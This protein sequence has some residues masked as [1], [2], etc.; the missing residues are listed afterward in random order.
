VTG[1][2]LAGIFAA[3]QST[4]SSSINSAA[5][6]ILCDL[7]KRYVRPGAGERESLHV[8]RAATLLAGLAGTGA[9]LALLRI[10]SALDAWWQLA[11]ILSG[12][13]L[14][15]FL[16]G[17]LSRAGSRAAFAAVVAG[18]LTILWLTWSPTDAWPD[19][20]GAL[21]SPFHGFL[22]IVLGTSTILVA[23]LLLAGLP[24]PRAAPERPVE[25]TEGSSP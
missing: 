2:V 14:G 5:T 13:M 21:R 4:I 8:L 3:A 10:Q 9:A 1:L 25:L 19:A 16:L 24:R 18:V 22:T 17:L 6:L 12:G 23:G 20:L 7:Y 11:G 15:L